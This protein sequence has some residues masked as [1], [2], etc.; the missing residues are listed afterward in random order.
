MSAE[1]RMIMDYMTMLSRLRA[2]LKL[3]LISKLTESLSVDY[4][5]SLKKPE[6][7]WKNL[8]GVWRDT[9]ENLATNIRNNRLPDREIL[10]FE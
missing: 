8:F 4:E 1:D 9:A 10:E 6:D 7:S 3:R 5:R 2:D